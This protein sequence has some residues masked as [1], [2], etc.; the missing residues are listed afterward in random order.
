MKPVNLR[1]SLCSESGPGHVLAVNAGWQTVWSTAWTAKRVLGSMCTLMKPD[2]GSERVGQKMFQ[3]HRLA[4][5]I[6]DAPQYRAVIG[7]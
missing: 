6:S 2:G 5:D 7:N 4:L 3:W 1:M